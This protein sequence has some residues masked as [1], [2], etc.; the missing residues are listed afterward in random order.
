MT[1]IAVFLA[2]MA[3]AIPLAYLGD[4][5]M[6]ILAN[7]DSP[8][9][10]IVRWGACAIAAACVVMVLALGAVQQFDERATARGIAEA[11]GG[12]K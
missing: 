11:N 12:A 7:D 8:S 2:S 10:R 6:S 9:P 4:Y 5:V 3:A 1:S